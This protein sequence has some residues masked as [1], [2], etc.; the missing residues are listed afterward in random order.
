MDLKEALGKAY[1]R[2]VTIEYENSELIRGYVTFT[3]PPDWTPLIKDRFMDDNARYLP[4]E[5]ITKIT[6][7]EN[8]LYEGDDND[9]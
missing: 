1:L 5:G 7:G 8:V 2:H 6:W 4:L 3:G 9:K